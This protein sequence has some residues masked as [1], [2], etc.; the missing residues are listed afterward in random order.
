MGRKFIESKTFWFQVIMWTV[1][2]FMPLMFIAPGEALTLVGYFRRAVIPIALLLVF[3]TNYLWLAPKYLHSKLSVRKLMIINF[4]SVSVLSLVL[5]QWGEFENYIRRE[6]TVA[7]DEIPVL[8]SSTTGVKF[9]LFLFFRDFFNLG[10]SAILGCSV[11]MFRRWVALEQAHQKAEVARREAELKNLRNQLN[12]HFL[13]NTL[14]NI[15]ALTAF[16]PT[17]ARTAV[18]E[19]G[20]ML[21]HILHDNQQPFVNLRDEADFLHN[22]VDLMKMRLADNVTVTEDVDIPSPCTVFIAPMLLISLVE[23]A[24][25]HGVSPTHPSEI[26]LHLSADTDTIIFE[27]RNTYFPKPSTDNSGHGIGLSQV[28]QRLDLAYP[29]KYEWKKGLN[30]NNLYTSTIIIH[31]TQLHDY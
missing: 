11:V 27:I 4:I 28:Q 3:Y 24:F 25:K 8:P 20:K 17:K 16:D 13:L 5:S 12:P 15:Y 9:H 7:N 23:N 18:M 22:Y 21:R 30:S 6:K 31:D 29:G 10:A 1:M 26:H 14:N 19:L 2:L